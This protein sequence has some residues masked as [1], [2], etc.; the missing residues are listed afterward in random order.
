M[1][2]GVPASRGR[3]GYQVTD[4]GSQSGNCVETSGTGMLVY[5][6]KM[7]VSRGYVPSSYL[8]V[9]QKAFADLRTKITND[10]RGQPVVVVLNELPCGPCV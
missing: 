7:G 4:K 1:S 5:A 2:R 10:A 3:L 9:A 6:I 8:D